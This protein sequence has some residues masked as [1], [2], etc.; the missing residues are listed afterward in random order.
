MDADERDI[1]QFLK[2]RSGEFASAMEICR[3]AGTKRRFHEDPNWAKPVLQRMVE[4]GI[5][6]HNQLGRYRI[7]PSRKN[8]KQ[9]I[10]PDIAKILQ[11]KGFSTEA[12]EIHEDDYYENL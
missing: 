12:V 9:W 4:R 2:S 11:E 3:R 1:F 8:K 7:K 6:E 10:A 5:L